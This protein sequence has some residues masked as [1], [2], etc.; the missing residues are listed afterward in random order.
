MHTSEEVTAK[1]A[2]LSECEK[3]RYSLWRQWSKLSDSSAKLVAFVG[4]NPSTADADT[5]DATIRRCVGFAKLWGY[6]GLVMLNCY[7]WRATDPKELKCN[8]D[9]VGPLNDHM[10]YY[11]AADE[12]VKEI[13]ACWG[14]HCDDTRALEVCCMINRPLSCLG[15]T[16]SG[17]PKHP[18]RLAKDTP[19]VGFWAPPE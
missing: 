13:I 11:W 8:D 1:G 12:R 6:D 4:L 5:D 19:R 9:V 3:Y 10:L 7:A 17:K 2:V 16:K 14:N 15:Q 18:V